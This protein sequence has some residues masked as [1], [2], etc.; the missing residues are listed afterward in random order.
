MAIE[1]SLS[2]VLE[3]IYQN[4]VALEAALMELVLLAEQQGNENSR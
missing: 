2:I 1:Y 3:K 4:Q